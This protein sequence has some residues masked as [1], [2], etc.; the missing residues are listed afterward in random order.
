M[1]SIPRWGL[2]AIP[3]LADDAVI[4]SREQAKRRPCR[5]GWETNKTSEE[6]GKGF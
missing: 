4:L 5:G 1:K 6:T 2:E 3:E